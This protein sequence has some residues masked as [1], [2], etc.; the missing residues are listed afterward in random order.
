M[1]YSYSWSAI[2]R[3]NISSGAQT[4]RWSNAGPVRLLLGGETH[5]SQFFP[6]G[7]KEFK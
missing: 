1:V 5:R 6:L 3:K 2:H 4:K 7:I